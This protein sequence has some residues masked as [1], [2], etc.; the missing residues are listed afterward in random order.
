[1]AFE[2]TIEEIVLDSASKMRMI[3][4]EFYLVFMPIFNYV[5]KDSYVVGK[6]Y[7]ELVAKMI[8]RDPYI[9]NMAYETLRKPHARPTKREIAIFGRSKGISYNDMAANFDISKATIL[10]HVKNH[11]NSDQPTFHP[12][13]PLGI[14]EDIEQY[15]KD[16]KIHF[17]PIANISNML[18]KAEK[19]VK[20]HV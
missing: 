15:L 16:I 19:K 20:K 6:Q 17:S 8:G 3:E 11:I 12:N 18:L 13:L 2:S 14:I 10:K 7:M 9:L 1:M 5:S 4:V